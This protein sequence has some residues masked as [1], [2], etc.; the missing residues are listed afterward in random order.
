MQSPASFWISKDADQGY[1]LAKGLTD[2]DLLAGHGGVLRNHHVCIG[3]IIQIRLHLQY[4]IV[5]DHLNMFRR[6]L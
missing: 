1:S 3:T 6:V 2:L 4:R 5:L